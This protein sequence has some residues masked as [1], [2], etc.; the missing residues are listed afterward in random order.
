MKIWLVVVD[1][2][3]VI[4]LFVFIGR[5]YIC[6]KKK[7]ERGGGNCKGKCFVFFVGVFVS[8]VLLSKILEFFEIVLFKDVFY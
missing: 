6:L 8:C 2:E 3:R 4:F 7:G 1:R 5:V